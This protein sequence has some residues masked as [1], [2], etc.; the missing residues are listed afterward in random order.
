MLSRAATAAVPPDGIPASARAAARGGAETPGRGSAQASPGRRRAA[1]ALGLTLLA[2]GAAAPAWAGS[3]ERVSVG[4]GGVQADRSSDEPALSADGRLVAFA[5][6]ATNLVAGDT[7]G[8]S[9]VFVHDRVTRQ[10]RRVSVGPGGAEGEAGSY[11]AT[12]SGDGRFV[13][14]HSGADNLVPGDTNAA[15]DTFVHD[16]GTGITERVSLGPGG[17]QANGVNTSARPGIS[18]N[19]R[20]V[21][22]C[23]E[24]T[25][26]VA[27]DTND[28]ADVF[29]HDRERG[30][31]RRVTVGLGGAEPNGLSFG[32]AISADG[33]HVAFWSFAT[34][35]VRGGDINN[36]RDVFVRDLATGTTREASVGRNGGQANG[37]SSDPTISADGRLVGFFSTAP[38]LVA[39]RHQRRR[40]RL[41]ARPRRGSDA[42]R[43]PDVARQPGQPRQRRAGAVGRRALRRLRLQGHQSRAGRHQPGDRRVRPEA[44]RAAARPSG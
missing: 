6:E 10:T 3:T 36:E 5:S 40:R 26:F 43:H 14:F 35:L 41:R 19:G 29:V 34:N 32:D 4:P 44:G 7:N 23:S 38:N 25:G 2:T 21:V 30:V 37:L 28:T 18:A 13:A 22:F 17:A 15:Y 20:F 9:D 1:A 16:L 42:A 24:A 33:R 8:E 31:T 12:I 39:G 11:R 27:A